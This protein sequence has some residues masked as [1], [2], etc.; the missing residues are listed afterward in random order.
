MSNY[1]S[2]SSYLLAVKLRSN[3]TILVE[4]VSDKKVLSHFILK[5]N[6]TD[7]IPTNYC[8]DDASLI[9]D[10]NLGAIGAKEKIQCIA[11]RSSSDNFRCLV[12]REWDGFNSAN[13]EYNAITAPN[14][15]FITKGHSIENYWFTSTSFIE[16]IIHTHHSNV[17]TI[18]LQKI[19]DLYINILHF[20]AAYSLACRNLSI[21]TRATDM[22][23]HENI[24]LTGNKFHASTCIDQKILSRGI[25]CT[26][27]DTIN[28]LLSQTASLETNK[29]QWICHGHLGEQAIR[30][31]I[32]KLAQLEGYNPETINSIEFGYKV[33]K[34]QLDSHHITALP[35][36]GSDP[37]NKV[38][39]WVR[40]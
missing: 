27:S 37:L 40:Q 24:L 10:K 23:S 17:T 6:H 11:G 29:L 39:D 19:N 18:Y 13:L 8:I 16:F 3:K 2:I 26:L 33:E 32:G 7:N 22:I 5:K 15:T 35:E 34:L 9:D 12:D 1:S 36:E 21:V 4:G 28:N 38:L 14:N 30:S 20:A 31:C 25:S